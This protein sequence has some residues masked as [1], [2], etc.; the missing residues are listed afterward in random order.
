MP[1]D[2]APLPPPGP[3]ARRR[4]SRA[5][6][7]PPPSPSPPSPASP[8]ADHHGHGHHAGRAGRRD[9]EEPIRLYCEGRNKI[10][11]AEAA[12]C[13]LRGASPRTGRGR[14]EA[15]TPATRQAGGGTGPN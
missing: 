14:G 13:D 2:F 9:M 7:A 1:L 4:L 12:G 11:S 5:A 3:H 15:R 6:P 10:N 8:A